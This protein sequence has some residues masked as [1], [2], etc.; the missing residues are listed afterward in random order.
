MNK[1]TT[2]NAEQRQV[3]TG[4]ASM[5]ELTF[6]EISVVSGGGNFIR[7]LFKNPSK[8]YDKGLEQI[9]EALGTGGTLQDWS[10]KLDKYL[11]KGTAR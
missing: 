5:R 4:N 11:G 1:G 6:E 2:K 10:D 7:D 9:D 8:L 3:S